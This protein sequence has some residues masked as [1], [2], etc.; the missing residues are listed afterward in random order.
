[1]LRNLNGR[2][3]RALCAV[4]FFLCRL[5]IHFRQDRP[6]SGLVP[7]ARGHGYAAEAVVALL[8]M[9]A[10]HGLSTVFA[11]TAL[12]NVASQRTL[13]RAGFRLISTDAALHHYEIPLTR[14]IAT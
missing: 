7:S 8:A 10:D 11:D 3:I 13:I 5:S 9:A 1:M 2:T 12:D 14:G 4:R 6:V